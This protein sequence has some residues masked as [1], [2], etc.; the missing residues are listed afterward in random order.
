[1]LPM[2]QRRSDRQAP[3][4][5]RRWGHRTLARAWRGLCLACDPAAGRRA[6]R[7][8]S[9][10]PPVPLLYRVHLERNP[11]VP[12]RRKRRGVSR[13]GG[14][15]CRGPA[16]YMHSSLLWV[17]G[18][19]ESSPPPRTS[20]VYSGKARYF[21]IMSCST[22]EPKRV[23]WTAHIYIILVPTGWTPCDVEPSIYS[24]A[25]HDAV[26]VVRAPTCRSVTRTGSG[27]NDPFGIARKGKQAPQ[28]GPVSPRRPASG[29]RPRSFLPARRR[30]V[31]WETRTG[32]GPH[33]DRIQRSG[34]GPAAGSAV[35]PIRSQRAGPL[36]RGHA[37]GQ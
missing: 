28:G 9:A 1:M 24:F 18:F 4:Q 6:S 34:R 32:R 25:L 12:R 16:E 3:G 37:R 31:G 29:P 14:V 36:P 26:H 19:S 5:S 17:R 21:A 13:R 7:R 35:P 20:L 30:P 8:S 15:S 10:V 33:Y 22:Q 11:L 23:P 27:R 2:D